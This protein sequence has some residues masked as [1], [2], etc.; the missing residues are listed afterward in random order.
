MNIKCL[1][2]LYQ[3]LVIFILEFRSVIWN[4]FNFGQ[5]VKLDNLQIR[6]ILKF[7]YKIDFLNMASLDITTQI[8]LVPLVSCFKYNDILFMFKLI[9]NGFP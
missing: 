3:A 8:G 4:P 5:I 1:T 6:F 9:N 2:A 7:R